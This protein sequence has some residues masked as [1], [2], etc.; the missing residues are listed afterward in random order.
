MTSSSGEMKE[1]VDW[2]L[3]F[4]AE[5]DRRRNIQKQLFIEKDRSHQ[6][7]LQLQKEK[8]ENRI[9]NQ[10]LGALKVELSKKQVS[11]FSLVDHV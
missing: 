5:V 2:K 7:S 9:L 3:R 1:S 6:F 4:D 11:K 8:E 10:Q